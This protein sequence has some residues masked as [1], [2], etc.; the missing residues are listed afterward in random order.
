MPTENRSFDYIIVGAG[1]AGCVLANRLS[2]SENVSICILEA[3]GSD[4]HPWIDIPAGFVK[5][6]YGDRFVWPFQ[7]QPVPS[8]NGR[9]IAL[10]QGKVIGGSSSINGMV[11]NRGQRADF[12]VWAQ[13]GNT[14]WGFDDL[15]PYFNK[16]EN[17]ISNSKIEHRGRNG[18]LP[19]TDL[20]WDNPL[21]DAFLKA[22]EGAGIPRVTDYNS[23]FQFG[24]GYFQRYILGGRR[25]SA[26]KAFLRPSLKRSSVLMQSKSQV[27]KLEIN[28]KKVSGVCYLDRSGKEQLVTANREIIL[29]A[30]AIN[31]PKIMQISGIGAPRHLN[32]IGVEVK[33]ALNGVG[34]NLRDHYSVRM[35]AKAK[36]VLTINELARWPRLPLEVLKWATARPSILSICPTI[37]FVHGKSS[38]SL[39]DA[40]IRILF[41]PG[42]Y[43][44]GKVYVLD[45]FPGLTC[46]AAQPRPDS[47]GYVRASSSNHDDPPAIQPN[48][49]YAETDKRI[50][51]AGL[52]LARK[53]L[54]RPE[55]SHYYDFETL[56][57]HDVQ[58]DDEL[59]D[60][61]MRKGNTGYH[62]VGTAKMGRLEDTTAVVDNQLKVH[63]LQGLRVIDASIMPTLP[64]ANTFASTIAIAEKGAD[65][66]LNNYRG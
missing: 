27:I 33:H 22:A 3:G 60:F 17:R 47:V 61:A 58:S 63:G 19:I 43:K 13:L 7:T 35:T 25:V 51:L 2:A 37:A 30:G 5:T 11:Y 44:D 14:G 4:R 31:T 1:A 20:D 41:T 42:S 55:L 49:L 12:D 38:P 39:E 32:S 54:E 40:D 36:N 50:T 46:G 26:A 59:L 6:L 57:G 64:S 24:A 34:E 16:S 10:P 62:V 45:D 8:L 65:I 18:E 48:Y 15:L 23:G 28:G 21:A 53:I 52:R 9:S 56:P 66:I 29:S